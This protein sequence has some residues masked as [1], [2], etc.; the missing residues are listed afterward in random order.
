MQIQIQSTP[1]K[2]II[3]F[4]TVK[5]T[6]PSDEIAKTIDEAVR[7]ASATS[8]RIVFDFNG[9]QVLGS[10]ILSYLIGASKLAGQEAVDMRLMNLRPEIL[11]VFTITGLNGLIRLDDDNDAEPTGARVPKP[12]PPEQPSGHA[13]L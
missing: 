8:K 1:N 6:D 13:G 9:V 7:L 12:K 3:T 4:G 2:V 5:L 11:E 10:S